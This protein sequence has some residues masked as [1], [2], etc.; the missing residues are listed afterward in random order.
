[1]S[2]IR[3][4]KESNIESAKPVESQPKEVTESSKQKLDESP[5]NMKSRSEAGGTQKPETSE[6]SKLSE[7]V[8]STKGDSA[9]SAKQPETSRGNLE[10]SSSPKNKAKETEPSANDS[11]EKSEKKADAA[12]NPEKM[13]KPIE[14]DFKCNPPEGLNKKQT[15]AYKVEFNRQ[16]KAQE[17]AMNKQSIAENMENRAKYQAEGRDNKTQNK[18][19]SDEIDKRTAA[20]TD[21]YSKEYLADADFEKGK[22]DAERQ[23]AAEK[24]AWFK[25]RAEAKASLKGQDAIHE[26]DQ[27]AG[28]N[29]E[30][31][32]GFGDSGVNRSIGVQWKGN[33]PKLAEAIDQYA[34]EHPQ[35]DL[36]KVKMNVKLNAA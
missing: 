29:P 36:S 12:K 22:S 16:L 14:L 1:M 21:K 13:E 4:N 17:N 3:E 35:E 20:L 8:P 9:R 34:K 32:Q 28:G 25:A 18:F 23:E 11:P 5:S 26:L 7:T 6:R 33:V 30:D 2:E 10:T 27:A 15:E 24:A 19:R 31:V